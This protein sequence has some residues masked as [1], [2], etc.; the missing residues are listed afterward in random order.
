MRDLPVRD[1]LSLGAWRMGLGCYRDS[2]RRRRM[3]PSSP[4]DLYTFLDKLFKPRF[5]TNLHHMEDDEVIGPS[6]FTSWR[7]AYLFYVY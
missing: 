2:F 7:C 1:M 3:S 6:K 4:V 5:F